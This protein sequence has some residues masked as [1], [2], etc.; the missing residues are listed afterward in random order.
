MKCIAHG[1]SECSGRS[2]AGYCN[3]H[4][5]QVKRHGTVA[6]SN[7]DKRP[8]TV[9]D[10]VVLIPLG[11]TAKDGYARVDVEYKHL[12]DDNWH[13]THYG[14]A[15]RAKDHALMHR[16]VQPPSQGMVIDHINGDKLDNRSCNLR[17]C[18]QAENSRNASLKLANKTG[19]RGVSRHRRS[20][21]AR[22]KYNYETH[23]LGAY[24]TAEEAA[25]AYDKG[26]KTLH[27]EFARLNY[28]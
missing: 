7:R 8:A 6:P 12:A 4:Y 15:R 20:F 22:V 14:Y 17:V 26:A 3:K 16:V 19:F 2:T 13:I 9:V 11:K 28:V 24:P 21:V 27:G 18:T 25:K 1:K 5:L 10:G 23:Y